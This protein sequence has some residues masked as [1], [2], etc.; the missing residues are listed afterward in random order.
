MSDDTPVSVIVDGRRLA[1]RRL[2]KALYPDTADGP[3]VT[4]AGLL[5][6]ARRVAPAWLTHLAGRPVTRKRW[7]DGV[8]GEVFFEKNLPR[9]TP[10][11]VP[12]VT[13]PAPGST[14]ERELVTY[15]V[16]EDL[17]TLVW[18]LNLAAL[19]LHV[20][21]WTATR[22]GRAH[23][24]DRLVVDLDPGPGTGLAEVSAV[25]A[26]AGARLAADGLR[27]FPVTSG[28]KGMQL[29]AAISGEQD[30][31][32]VSG[33]AKR[34]AEALEREHRGLVVSRMAKDLRPGKVFV[35]WSQNNP[36]KTTV[37]PYSPRGVERPFAAAPR[38]W[39][40]LG[41]GLRHL[42]LDEV[43]TRVER[44]GDLLGGLVGPGPRVP[45]R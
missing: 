22:D 37:C 28:S 33:Y 10:D 26:W 29:Y 14:K 34:L 23:H 27:P 31:A 30:G 24:P 7:P 35:D 42:T 20:P 32:T 1:L 5:D 15:P 19:E 3:G 44:D 8:L 40:E 13:L 45:Q 43:A 39:D 6:Y 25:A 9:G 12:R 41:D 21:Q 18:V 17:P 36:A 38:R 4:K 16:V 11:W 2:D